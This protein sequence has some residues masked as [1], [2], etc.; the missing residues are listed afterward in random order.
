M[1][2]DLDTV[3]NLEAG[4]EFSPECLVLKGKRHIVAQKWQENKVIPVAARNMMRRVQL[5][6]DGKESLMDYG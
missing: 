3:M 5:Y 6:H 1:E 2:V 4:E